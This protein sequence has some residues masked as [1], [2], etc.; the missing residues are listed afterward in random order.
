MRPCGSAFAAD[1]HSAAINLPFSSQTVGLSAGKIAVVRVA[2]FLL[3]LRLGVNRISESL[4]QLP[5]GCPI[6]RVWSAVERV[7]PLNRG[8]LTL[9]KNLLYLHCAITASYHKECQ[10]RFENVS[11]DCVTFIFPCHNYN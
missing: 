3:L 8:T 6:H 2:S 1:S 9:N 11:T 4:E 5:R 10:P 7:G